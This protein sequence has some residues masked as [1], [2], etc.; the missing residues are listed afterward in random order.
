MQRLYTNHDGDITCLAISQDRQFVATGQAGRDALIHIWHAGS[1]AHLTTLPACHQNAIVALSFSQ[2]DSGSSSW[3]ASVGLDKSNSH[4]VW[5]DV[6]GHWSKVSK[7]ATGQGDADQALFVNWIPEGHEFR[8]VSGGVNHIKFWT[9][10]GPTLRGRKGLFG[11]FNGERKAKPKGK[12]LFHTTLL[13]SVNHYTG[14]GDSGYQLLTGSM[15]GWIDL[16]EGR[17]RT[18]QSFQPFGNDDAVTALASVV[19]VNQQPNPDGKYSPDA[20]TSFLVVGNDHGGI[21]VTSVTQEGKGPT[22]FIYDLSLVPHASIQPADKKSPPHACIQSVDIL[23]YHGHQTHDSRHGS[24]ILVGTKG[25]GIFEIAAR[26]KEGSGQ[27]EIAFD[28]PPSTPVSTLVQ[29]HHDG[30]LWGLAVD[31]TTESNS[32]TKLFASCGDDCILRVWSVGLDPQ[33]KTHKRLLVAQPLSE[34]AESPPRDPHRSR[35]VAWSSHNIIAVGYSQQARNANKLESDF[36]LFKFECLADDNEMTASL[37]P[38]PQR[39]SPKDLPPISLPSISDMKFIDRGGDHQSDLAVAG[40]RVIVTFSIDLSGEPKVVEAHRFSLGHASADISHI[41]WS[42]DGEHLR[43]NCG[44]SELL[45]QPKHGEVDQGTEKNL[46]RELRDAK[47]DS[48]TCTFE[49]AVQGIW[50]DQANRTRINAV[51]TSTNSDLLVVAGD[52]GS[53]RLYKYPCVSGARCITVPA[54]SQRV[55]NVRFLNENYFLTCSC[56][57]RT[58]LLWR[59]DAD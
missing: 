6:G 45:Y 46:A 51:H 21:I 54:H 5:K 35:A 40:G 36:L 42:K 26:A 29:G 53:I 22:R 55:T 43:I 39:E 44:T 58:V 25:S 31:P 33:K 50:S 24:R 57:S 19:N 1:C 10:N 37:I 16:W 4:A 12:S 15:S 41:D 34:G 28:S 8:L 2:D 56:E 3:L 32:K 14:S 27:T 38:L 30:E 9:I 11:S 13:C 18:A 47:W 59:V 23:G 20:S 17:A 48:S 7:V 52:D 49:W